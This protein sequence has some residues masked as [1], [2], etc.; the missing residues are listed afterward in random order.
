MAGVLNGLMRMRSLKR[1]LILSFRL[2][3]LRRIRKW[4]RHLYLILIKNRALRRKSGWKRLRKK[5]RRKGIRLHSL[6]RIKKRLSRIN[7]LKKKIEV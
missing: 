2:I 5:K 4:E 3:K 1:K 7:F 6:N